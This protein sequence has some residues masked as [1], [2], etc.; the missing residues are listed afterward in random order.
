[1]L[2]SREYVPA[3]VAQREA[4]K[5]YKTVANILMFR[6]A[7]LRRANYYHGRPSFAED[8][9]LSVQLADLGYGNVYVSKVLAHYRVWGD[10]QGLRHHRKTLHFQGLTELFHGSFVAAFERRGWNLVDVRRARSRIA[11]RFA[12]SVFMPWIS[13]DERLELLPLLYRLD[14]GFRVRRRVFLLQ[15]VLAPIFNT[16]ARWEEQCRRLAKRVLA[17]IGTRRRAPHTP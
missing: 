17:V 15:L 5:G 13:D 10:A 1:M 6:A 2:R 11:V 4:L 8:Y 16:L 14:D 12:T 3:D 7:A 9:D